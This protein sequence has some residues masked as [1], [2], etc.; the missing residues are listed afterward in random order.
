MEGDCRV[1]EPRKIHSIP[2]SS[3]GNSDWIMPSCTNTSK[4]VARLTLSENHLNT[5]Y[6]MLS[7]Y[8][9]FSSMVAGLKQLPL[10]KKETK[11]IDHLELWA[12][13]PFDIGCCNWGRFVLH[14]R[15]RGECA[16]THSGWLFKGILGVSL[17]LVSFANLMVTEDYQPLAV[18]IAD[19][20]I[21][22]N[23]FIVLTLKPRN[24]EDHAV[25]TSSFCH[26]LHY[27]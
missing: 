14:D 8:A 20:R 21:R 9:S 15:N 13:L 10:H 16:P 3:W 4:M 22:I 1:E 17:I 25:I 26:R 24:C 23:V 7:F 5:D 2:C 27:R 12:A 11:T 18:R 19:S 6:G